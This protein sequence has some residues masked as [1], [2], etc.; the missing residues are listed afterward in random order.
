MHEASWDSRSTAKNYEH[1]DHEPVVKHQ[2]SCWLREVVNQKDMSIDRRMDVERDPIMLRGWDND[3]GT[4]L[5]VFRKPLFDTLIS[6]WQTYT[7]RPFSLS[8]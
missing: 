2:L 3:E 4:Y 7:L 5:V 6:T 8:S 1:A